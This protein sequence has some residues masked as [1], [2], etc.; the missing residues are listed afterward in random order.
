MLYSIY[1]ILLIYFIYSSLCLLIPFLICPS[2]FSPCLGNHRFSL[3]L[4][5]IY[6]HLYNFLDSTYTDVYVLLLYPATL[7]NSFI[8]ITFLG[9]DFRVLFIKS[10]VSSANS[11]SFAS[12]NLDTFYFFS[13]S[14]C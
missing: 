14:D 10:I 3:F 7:L 11:D 1:K 2:P 5:C 9:G 4:F 8:L 6:I 13:L 12:S